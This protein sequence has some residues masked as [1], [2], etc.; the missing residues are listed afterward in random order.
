MSKLLHISSSPRGE[1]SESLRIACVFVQAYRDANPD[2]AVESWDLWDGVFRSS[3]PRRRG[4][5]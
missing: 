3:V 5:R 4:P 2:A 1:A